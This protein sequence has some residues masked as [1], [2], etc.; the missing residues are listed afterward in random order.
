MP[1]ATNIVI[2][3]GAPSPVAHTFAPLGKDGKGVFWFEQITPAP[4]NP[5]GAKRI[6]VS[7]SRPI[8]G[9]RLSGDAKAVIS[10]YEPVLE[11]LG[12]NSAG[13]T[14]PPTLAYQLVGRESVSLA[15]R[16]TKQERRDL[17]TLKR[18]LLDNAL[19]VSMIDDLQ[20][21]Y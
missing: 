6:G 7:L 10:I 13:I 18:N 19:I 12:T 2:N 9:N 21:I 8:N 3:D 17:R 16:S 4:A 20:P 14:P 1:Q 11:T 15:E 5:L